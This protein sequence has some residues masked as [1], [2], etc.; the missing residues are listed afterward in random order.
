MALQ[1]ITIPI[2][3]FTSTAIA[4]INIP[5]LVKT[6]ARCSFPTIIRHYSRGSYRGS[7]TDNLRPASSSNTRFTNGLFS[8]PNLHRPQDFLKLANDAIQDCNSLR[9]IIQSSLL[10]NETDGTYSLSPRETLHILDNISN[11]VCS[12]IDASELCRSV[13]FSDEW[14]HEA[15]VA[16]Q[17]L[18]AYIAE[19]NADVS[20]YQS[21]VPITSNA[22]IMSSLSEEERRMATLL[23]KEFERDS[24][25]LPDDER[26]Q[27]RQLNAFVVQLETMFMENLTEH[28]RFNLY[29][30]LTNDVYRTI[31]KHIIEQNIPQNDQGQN[32]S[33]LDTSEFVTLT[34][35]PHIANSLLKYSPSSALRK[36]VFMEA[37]TQCPQNLQVLDALIQQ[38][39]ALAIKMGYPSYTHY[40]LSDKMASSPDNVASFLNHVRNAS[41]DK[42]NRDLEIL[43]RAKAQIEGT[44]QP[45]QPWDLSYYISIV[46]NH[47]CEGYDDA[48]EESLA[49]YFTLDK[50]LEGMKSLVQRLFGI[51][52]V[53]AS[54]TLDERWDNAESQSSS[55]AS[56][57]RKFE[58]YQEDDGKPLGTMYLD[59]YPRP[60]K[61]THAAHFTVRCGCESRFETNSGETQYQLPIVALV[62]NLSPPQRNLG[63][64]AVLSHSEVETMFHE[65][66][67]AMHSLLSRTSFQHLSG[68]RSAMDFVETPSH[69]M[70][71]YVWNEEFLKMIGRH[72]QTGDSIPEKNIKNLIKSRT[73]FK[74]LEVQSQW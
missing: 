22:S 43:S 9:Q 38:R 35:E 59:L 11:T 65:F 16:F 20:L 48:G 4:S 26:A 52:M 62:F 36:E 45:L 29:G 73:L 33:Y 64:I 31:P 46:K 30:S 42:Y 32:K 47:L 14:R 40:F 68:T 8:L 67:H 69:L 53:E 28:K 74:A 39:H 54:M 21:L 44:L 18:S 6:S 3:H 49:G 72:Y 17:M 15:S 25:H 27:V 57:I 71:Y 13:H 24:I 7:S 61:Y 50:T 37:N 41:K 60:G 66:G 23:Q 55:E 10:H 63:S 19:L 56:G 2:R 34:T 1:R 5:H 12:V 51:T 70:E 58:F